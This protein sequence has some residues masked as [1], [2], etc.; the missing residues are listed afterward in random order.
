M[1]IQSLGVPGGPSTYTC[2][3]LVLPV[4]D[5]SGLWIAR[6]YLSGHPPLW[7]C[8]GALNVC[9]LL[10]GFM[11]SRVIFY[12]LTDQKDKRTFITPTVF[13]REWWRIYFIVLSVGM[14]SGVDINKLLT[15][16]SALWCVQDTLRVFHCLAIMASQRLCGWN[17]NW[18]AASMCSLCPGTEEQ[19][20]RG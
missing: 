10:C 7:K 18:S 9:S 19:R 3:L 5:V 4:M 20:D 11:F 15:S 17:R 13:W 1:S 12:T 6:W 16:A 2:G 14:W 8:V